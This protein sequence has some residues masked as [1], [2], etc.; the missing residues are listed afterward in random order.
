MQSAILCSEQSQGDG[1][2]FN[3]GDKKAEIE[4]YWKFGGDFHVSL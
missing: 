2:F 1:E 4:G 3:Q